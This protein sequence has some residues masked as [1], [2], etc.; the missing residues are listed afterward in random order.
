MP[1]SSSPMRRRGSGVAAGTARCRGAGRRGRSRRGRSC[2]GTRC[3]PRRARSSRSP[4]AD[5]SFVELGERH[6]RRGT[7]SSARGRWR[8]PGTA[9]GTAT[10]GSSG[11]VCAEHLQVPQL[12]AE[13]EFAQQ[14][15]AELGD[16]RDRPVR[17]AT[18]AGTA[19]PAP[20]ARPGSTGRS[21]R[22]GTMSGCC[23]FTTTSRPSWQ[24]GPVDLA[25]R[26]RRERHGVERARTAR[27]AACR[28]PPRR[29]PS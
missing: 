20:P 9:P 4:P 25:D 15:A 18:P 6:A 11:E 13:V 27:R 7:P 1:A 14:H 26:R 3:A 17:A 22:G 12:A 28:V 10:P 2:R 21:R 16:H 5:F 19:R 8:A 29:S 23:T 24:R